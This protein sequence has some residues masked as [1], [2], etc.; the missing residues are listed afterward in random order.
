MNQEEGGPR[1]LSDSELED[2]K[3]AHDSPIEW[4]AK[5]KRTPMEIL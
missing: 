4:I 2:L 1:K 5:H 3:L